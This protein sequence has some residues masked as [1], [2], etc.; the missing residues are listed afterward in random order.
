M[1]K[2]KLIKEYPGS[3]EL[4]EIV[5][6]GSSSNFYFYVN[7]D[8]CRIVIR[9]TLVDNQPDYWE[10]VEDNK[11]F[12]VSKRD[13]QKNYTLFEAWYIYMIDSYQPTIKDENLNY[14]KIKEEAEDFIIYN[15]PCLSINEIGDSIPCTTLDRLIRTVK[16][17]L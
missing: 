7:P 12:V 16:S 1:K 9:K 11:W 4:G 10:E 15:K 17:K 5:E 6:G 14:F 3:P 2:Y 8:L 13:Y